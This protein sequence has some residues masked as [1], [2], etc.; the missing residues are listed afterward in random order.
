MNIDI[1]TLTAQIVN[2]LVLIFILNKLLYKPL[3]KMMKDRR[4]YIK[5]SID[6]ADNK[7]QEAERIRNEYEEELKKI[8][9][10]KKEKIEKIDEELFDYKNNEI[11]K[12]KEDL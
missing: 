1:F 5:N 6:N 11:A 4:E 8:E 3:I 10:Y 2:F 7:L 9:N 12:I